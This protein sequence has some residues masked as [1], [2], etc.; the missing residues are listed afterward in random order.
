MLVV[1][2]Q[3]LRL[4]NLIEVAISLAMA[5]AFLQWGSPKPMTRF[6]SPTTTAGWRV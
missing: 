2:N 3:I 5:E 6:S 4:R 1:Y